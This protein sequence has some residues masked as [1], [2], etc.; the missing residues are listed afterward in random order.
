MSFF[1]LFS[2]ES[3]FP[4]TTP[5]LRV[6]RPNLISF[7]GTLLEVMM[8]CMILMIWKDRNCHNIIFIIWKFMTPVIL[9]DLASAI[10]VTVLEENDRNLFYFKIWNFQ[11]KFS[12]TAINNIDVT[13]TM[14]VPWRS[15]RSP[16]NFWRYHISHLAIL[17]QNQ[18]TSFH[19]KI[20]SN[21]QFHL[22]CRHSVCW[23]FR[24]P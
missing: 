9:G 18:M 3:F 19:F 11:L 7:T 24:W 1:L 21:H 10:A 4:R 15:L 13:G 16:L 17:Y 5:M 22:L 2:V 20:I 6:P 14:E 8:I 23:R 12:V